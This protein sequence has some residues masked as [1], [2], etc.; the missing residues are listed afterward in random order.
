[1]LYETQT[2][3]F[4]C[5]LDAIRTE[6][7]GLLADMLASDPVPQAW[8]N[9]CLRQAVKAE[10]AGAVQALLAVGADPADSEFEAVRVASANPGHPDILRALLAAGPAPQHLLMR[11]LLF[12][13]G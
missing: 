5:I 12:P 7:D 10:N 3:Q 13:C 4:E 2:R 1:M 9:Y 11:E 6:N 8:L